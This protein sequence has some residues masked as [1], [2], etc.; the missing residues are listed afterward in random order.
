MLFRLAVSVG[1]LVASAASAQETLEQENTAYPNGLSERPLLVGARSG[2]V[3]LLAGAAVPFGFKS[4]SLNA[5]GGLPVT[6]TGLLPEFRPWTTVGITDRVQLSAPLI[7]TLGFGD[8]TAREAPEWALSLGVDSF[9]IGSAVYGGFLGRVEMRS[10]LS[11]RGGFR[12]GLQA[13]AFTGSLG[14]FL[15]TKLSCQ[16]IYE[17]HP[18][19]SLNG[20]ASLEMVGTA[21]VR[22]VTFAPAWIQLGGLENPLLAFHLG[23]WDLLVAPGAIVEGGEAS[24]SLGGGFGWRW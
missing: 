13:R 1:L 4:R 11:E 5:G 9:G 15:S 21:V 2:S 20:G 16:L 19:V 3:G 14:T 17:L 22:S 24:W 18:Y 7:L 10:L 8:R 6:S 23:R 12:T